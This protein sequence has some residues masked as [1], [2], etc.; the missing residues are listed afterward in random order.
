M[1]LRVFKEEHYN[2]IVILIYKLSNDNINN[3]IYLYHRVIKRFNSN[4]IN[5][6]YHD[7]L[8]MDLN[9]YE[10]Y[11]E[12]ENINLEKITTSIPADKIMELD[13]LVHEAMLGSF[14]L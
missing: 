3:R 10:E 1:K 9:I 4:G 6:I 2:R 11:L 13:I 8:L 14:Y 7:K 12:H 5:P